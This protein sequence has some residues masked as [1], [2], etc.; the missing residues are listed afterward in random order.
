MTEP[1]HMFELGDFVMHV[2]DEQSDGAVLEAT[3]DKVIVQWYHLSWAG[4][5]DGN[6]VAVHK[7]E[8]LVWG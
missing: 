5:M 8:E 2:D 6:G 7:P 4:P 3:E 1:K